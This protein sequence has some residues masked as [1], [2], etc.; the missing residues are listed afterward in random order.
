MREIIYLFLNRKN[1][2]HTFCKSL[3]KGS[4]ENNVYIFTS[5]LSLSR[6]IE[7]FYYFMYLRAEEHLM[8]SEV[9]QRIEGIVKNIWP[10]ARVN[11]TF[12]FSFGKRVLCAVGTPPPPPLPPPPPPPSMY[13][14]SM[15]Y[16]LAITSCN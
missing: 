11:L 14:K 9:V 3:S 12:S 6:E 4:R 8:R 15:H 16:A 7:E 1:I 5:S 13:T 2:L 10:D